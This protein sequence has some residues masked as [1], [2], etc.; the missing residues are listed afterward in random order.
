MIDS[1]QQYIKPNIHSEVSIIVVQAHWA[2]KDIYIYINTYANAYTYIY[3]YNIKPMREGVGEGNIRVSGDPSPVCK[4]HQESVLKGIQ[5]YLC[6]V[7][8][9][10]VGRTTI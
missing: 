7:Q 8:T 10:H 4:K 3:K 1:Q 5:S 9:G 6:L 2:G